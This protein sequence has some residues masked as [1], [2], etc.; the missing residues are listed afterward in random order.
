MC[1]RNIGNDYMIDRELQKTLSYTGISGVSDQD[2]AIQDSQGLI[3]DR[4]REHLG[5]TDV[6]IVEFR[7]LL[8][9]AARCAGERP[10][11]ACG[12]G[13]KPICRALRWL[14]RRSRQTLRR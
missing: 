5:P 14:G 7:K 8:L 3:Q 1:R 13:C 12:K 10:E 4:T 6:G 2:A 9:G 11:P